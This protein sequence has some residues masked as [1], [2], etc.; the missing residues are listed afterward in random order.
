MIACISARRWWCYT[1]G[2]ISLTAW[3]HASLLRQTFVALPVPP[4]R[5]ITSGVNE[6][7][8]T[9]R[10]LCSYVRILHYSC[11]LYVAARVGWRLEGA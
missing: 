6:L 8:S 3:R 7:C 2:P 4:V 5:D 10:I 9:S 1:S 11:F